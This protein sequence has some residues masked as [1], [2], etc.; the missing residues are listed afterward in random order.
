ML[1]TILL[2]TLVRHIMC[3]PPTGMFR[4]GTRNQNLFCMA[5]LSRAYR[6]LV[7]TLEI[8]TFTSIKIMYYMGVSLNGGTPKT[9]QNDQ[10]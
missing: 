9:P 6:I 10:F 1:D 2:P 8:Q 7:Q 4:K 3:L 5:N